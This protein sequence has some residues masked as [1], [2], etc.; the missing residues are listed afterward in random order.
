MVRVPV[1]NPIEYLLRRKFP[2]YPAPRFSR[3]LSA[4]DSD[5][6]Q[7][8]IEEFRAYLQR[9]SPDELQAL[10]VE[11]QEHEYRAARAAAEREEQQRP[12]NRA[13]AKAD[14]EHWS[15]AAYW[16][17]DEAIALS[18]GKAPEV[19]TWESVKPYT[20][21]SPFARKYARV[22]DLALRAKVLKQLFEPAL[23]GFF[24]AW[25]RR[26]E[27][28]APAELIELLEKRG[29]VVANWKDLHDKLKVQCDE[30]IKA[31]NLKIQ[32][33]NEAIAKYQEQRTSLL[34]RNEQLTAQVTELEATQW[35]G[36]DPESST[37]PSELDIAMLA[38]RGATR[39][40]DPALTAKEQIERWLD[41]HYPDRR[42]LS[43]D[44][45]QRIAVVCNWEKS[46]G[47]RRRDAK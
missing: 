4:V 28:E 35:E 23:P 22:R 12:F 32:K 37:Y 38:W 13:M 29:I 14:F 9:K 27:I 36:F 46:G 3:T 17:L 42:L 47:R 44:A 11:E 18:F 40:S 1:P 41:L 15:K 16:T 25:A 10:C 7:S 30:A 43:P 45:R 31:A 2:G 33:G 34:Q 19:V 8:E 24:L 5:P 6:R 39:G 20:G 21:I 26:N